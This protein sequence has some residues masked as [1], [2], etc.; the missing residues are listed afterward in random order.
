MFLEY[1]SRIYRRDRGSSV[2]TAL[3]GE[4]GERVTLKQFLEL[5]GKNDR[6][7]IGPDGKK[8]WSVQPVCPDCGQSVHV[9]DTLG[10]LGF[11]AT[12]R[13]VA[14]RHRVPGFHHNDNKASADCP[15][16]FA[17]DPQMAQIYSHN[18]FDPRERARNEEICLSEKMLIANQK[19]LL[20]LMR[21]LTGASD[22]SAEDQKKLD[23][24][25]DSKLLRMKGIN[26]HPWTIPFM[27]VVAFGAHDRRSV[28]TGKTYRAVFETVGQQKLAFTDSDNRP[29]DLIV[30]ISMRLCFASKAGKKQQPMKRYK[31]GPVISVEV[32]RQSAKDMIIAMRPVIPSS[33]ATTE[34]LA[35]IAPPA[36][37]N[38]KN[39]GKTLDSTQLPLFE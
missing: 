8:G 19:I 35:Q 6:D 20:T 21:E 30:P 16:S 4:H 15:S 18:K 9:Y 38:V 5:E 1:N 22:I 13:E 26:N 14:K 17:N 2:R 7:S 34:R 27:Q 39:P 32:S 31:N 24:I 28:R 25:R 12:S 3:Y 37:E 33:E 11:K 23:K 29:G 36:R 10:A